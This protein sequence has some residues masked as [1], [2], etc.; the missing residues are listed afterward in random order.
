MKQNRLIDKK[1]I[2]FFNNIEP[3]G[4]LY[5]IVLQ[6]KNGE[7]IPPLRRPIAAVTHDDVFILT[8]DYELISFLKKY[9]LGNISSDFFGLCNFIANVNFDFERGKLIKSEEDIISSKHDARFGTRFIFEPKY[10]QVDDS[11]ESIEFCSW[12]RPAIYYWKI[13]LINNTVENIKRKEIGYAGTHW[14]YGSLIHVD[15]TTNGKWILH[16]K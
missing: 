2:E 9:S 11:I 13:K 8:E 12:N 14:R 10:E 15:D 5:D 1:A 6:S 16:Q 4:K 7:S 3:N